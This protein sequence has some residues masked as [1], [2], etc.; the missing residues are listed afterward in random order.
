MPPARV[1]VQALTVFGADH[2]GRIHSI[3]VFAVLIESRVVFVIGLLPVDIRVG[4]E[5]VD[6]APHIGRDGTFK[7]HPSAADGMLQL[8]AFGVQRLTPEPAQHALEL[9]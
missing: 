1:V 4:G 2:V 9:V 8:Q 5:R 7:T 3:L 6:D